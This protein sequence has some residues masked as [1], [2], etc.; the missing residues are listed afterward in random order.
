MLQLSADQID[1]NMNDD[2][3]REIYLAVQKEV[4]S[5]VDT[6]RGEHEARAEFESAYTI[7]RGISGTPLRDS[8][9]LGQTIVNDYG[10]PY[11]EGFNNYTGFSCAR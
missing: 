1:A 11:G 8:Y 2:E 4:S 6:A 3:A 7:L 10:R 9:H 5:D